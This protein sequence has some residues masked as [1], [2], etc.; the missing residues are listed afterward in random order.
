MTMRRT[1]GIN[2]TSLN[3][4]ESNFVVVNVVGWA[5]ERRPDGAVL[6]RQMKL[7]S[8]SPTVAHEEEWKGIGYLQLNFR[9]E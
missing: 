5:R 9:Y 6:H 3:A 7:G 1:Q 4:L 2:L 8:P